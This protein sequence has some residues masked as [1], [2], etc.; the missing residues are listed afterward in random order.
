MSVPAGDAYTYSFL[1]IFLLIAATVTVVIMK[2]LSNEKASL[3]LVIW[4]ALATLW[5]VVL[6]ISF[7]AVCP[8]LFASGTCGNRTI[9]T[10]VSVVT[11]G[12]VILDLFL[13]VVALF[14]ASASRHAP[15]AV[16]RKRIP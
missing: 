3:R 4:L 2:N 13:L 9:S 1:L 8:F 14:I 5:M 12:S 11:V 10:A 7:Q 15:T 16:D 6:I